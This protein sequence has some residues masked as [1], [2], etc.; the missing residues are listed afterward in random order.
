MSAALHA[1]WTKLRTVAGPAWLLLTAAAL[2]MGLSAGAVAMMSCPRAGCDV[3]ATRLSLTGIQLGQVVVAVLAVLVIGTE[4]STGMIGTTLTAMPRRT[5]VLAAKAIVLT[6][7]VLTAATLGVLGSVLAGQAI[8]PRHGVPAVSLA[9]GATM[10]AA[11]GSILYLA[12]IG[13][14][15]L[16]IAA[17][18][19][20]SA[21]AIGI[22]LGL[23]YVFPILI[24]VITNPTWQRHL[25][26]LAPSNA[27][28]AIQ[29]T[30][31]LPDLPIGP[32]AGLGVLTAWAAAALLA[33]ATVLVLRDA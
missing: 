31:G 23:L 4:Y 11:G 14:L 32:W 17:L 20:D 15:S 19:R 1:E 25:R 6:A 22:V 10:R 2:T 29:S 26:Q 5:A 27:G 30:T 33:G 28:L 21:A 16:G 13:L 24:G 7:G 12:L 9:H 3:D 18:V 8:L